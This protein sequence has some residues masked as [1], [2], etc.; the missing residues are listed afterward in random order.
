MLA[1]MSVTVGMAA[2]PLTADMQ[3]AA[4]ASGGDAMALDPANGDFLG[5][6]PLFPFLPS[7]HLNSV[8]QI[9]HS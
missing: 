3:R 1:G 2:E 4:V 5:T 7:R 8:Q 6:Q 9:H